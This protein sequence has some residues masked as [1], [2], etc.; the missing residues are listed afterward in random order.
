VS[1]AWPIPNVFP[2]LS[3]GI[4]HVW[5][6]NLDISPEA[7]SSLRVHMHDDEI[8]RAERFKFDQHR[9]RFIACRGQV[10]QILAKY[11]GTDP[12]RLEFA[13]GEKGKPVL[14]APWRDSRIEFNVSHS[15]ELALCAVALGRELGVDI[16]EVRPPYDFE[17]IAN[18][19]FGTEEVAVLNGLSGEAKLAGFFACW[20][21]KEA[22]LK[23]VGT[24]LS[25]PLNRVIVAI[26]PDEPAAVLKFKGETGEQQEWWMQN[27]E[28]ALGYAGAVTSAGPPLKM[29]C[30]QFD[31]GRSG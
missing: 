4:V 5:S 16:E 17:A 12:D 18:Q 22:V 7:I 15:H 28:P 11:T 13:Y 20:T 8:A 3:S 19:F 2:T 26:L 31:P 23:A 27:L 10:R 25:I 29:E 14:A 21:R 24:G 1:I 30:W 6:L 9:R